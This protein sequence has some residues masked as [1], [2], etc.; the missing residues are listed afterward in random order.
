MSLRLAMRPNAVLGVLAVAAFAVVLAVSNR[1]RLPALSSAP[2]DG[3]SAVAGSSSHASGRDSAEAQLPLHA[4]PPDAAHGNSLPAQS[5]TFAA[6][7]R[8]MPAPAPGAPSAAQAAPRREPTAEQLQ[9][10]ARL[11]QQVMPREE[12]TAEEAEERGNAIRQLAALPGPQ[13]AQALVHAIRNDV[14]PRNRILAVEALRRAGANGDASW[15]IRDAL[16]EAASSSDEV[17]A[18]QARAAYDELVAKLGT[19]R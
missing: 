2:F 14:D 18:A 11:S 12:T 19:Q 13:A 3:K 15:A 6:G 8:P 16:R 5:Q 7:Q 9:T 4:Q 10:I 1:E 17:V